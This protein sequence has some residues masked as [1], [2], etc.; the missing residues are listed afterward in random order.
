MI[1]KTVMIDDEFLRE[2][3]KDYDPK[4]PYFE[5][6]SFYSDNHQYL[7]EAKSESG[8]LNQSY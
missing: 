8:I 6:S 1:S 2:I 3:N 4:E 5:M 7:I